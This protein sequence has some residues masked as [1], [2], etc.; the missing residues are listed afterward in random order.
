SAERCGRSGASTGS[1]P[2]SSAVCAS[3]AGRGGRAGRGVTP[4]CHRLPRGRRARLATMSD[5]RENQPIFARGAVDLSTL[6]PPPAAQP[7]TA[8]A[9]AAGPTPASGGPAPAGPVVIDVTEATFQQEVLERS[10]HTPVVI[11]FWAEWCGPCRQLSPVLERLAVE[12]GGAWVLA[13]VDVDAN[14]RL[15]QMFGSR[16]SR[17]CTPSSA[18]SPSTRSPG[19]CPSP[20]CGPGS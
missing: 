19:R 14:P 4:W 1:R 16:G 10:M 13:K 5:P 2:G 17:W 8:P 20:S 18:A 15:A 11:D 12:Y 6:R 9:G 3:A 7:A